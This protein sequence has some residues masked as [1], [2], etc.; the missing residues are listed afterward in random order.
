MIE[1]GYNSLKDIHGTKMRRQIF[2]TVL[3][4][5]LVL[6]FM[7]LYSLGCVYVL[8]NLLGL[9]DGRNYKQDLT[10]IF[11]MCIEP[12]IILAILSILNLNFFGEIVAV[13]TDEGVYTK[14]HFIDW[15]DITEIK[16]YTPEMP[17]K[18]LTPTS[19][20]YTE[21]LCLQGTR[22]IYHMPLWFLLKAKR[23]NK[24]IKLRIK[25]D[26]WYIFFGVVGILMPPSML[27]L[28]KLG[29]T[30]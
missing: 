10:S 18:N 17:G 22:K 2:F 9:G 14:K 19:F 4:I 12:I 27:I 13:L 30:F 29:F 3:V 7:F 16:F 26:N 24:Q 5:I 23:F 20:A 28:S 8:E 25:I 6:V 1:R 21:I 15:N 11:G